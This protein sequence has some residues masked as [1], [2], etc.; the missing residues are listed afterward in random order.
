[1]RHVFLDVETT[2]LSPLVHRVVCVGTKVGTEECILI[3][4]DEKKILEEFK[5]TIAEGDVLVAV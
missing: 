3:G 5:N 1:M 2:G 4:R